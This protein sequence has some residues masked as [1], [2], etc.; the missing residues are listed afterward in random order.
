MISAEDIYALAYSGDI[1][2]QT[3]DWLNR[4]YDCIHEMNALLVVAPDHKC[5]E[6]EDE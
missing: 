4:F 6:T 2:D 3:Y 1:H 5:V